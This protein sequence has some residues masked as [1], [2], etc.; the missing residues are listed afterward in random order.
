MDTGIYWLK[1]FAEISKDDTSLA[2]WFPVV[3]RKAAKDGSASDVP[4]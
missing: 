2:A 3:E 1:F 4:R